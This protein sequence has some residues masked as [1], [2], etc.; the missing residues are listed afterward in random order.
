MAK[1]FAPAVLTRFRTQSGSEEDIVAFKVSTTQKILYVIIGPAN[2]A[3]SREISEKV[4]IG[5]RL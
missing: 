1:K 4:D 3:A 5:S 2:R